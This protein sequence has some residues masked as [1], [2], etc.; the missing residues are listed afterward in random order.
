MSIKKN[1]Q[2]FVLLALLEHHTKFPSI[3]K[4]SFREA[5]FLNRENLFKF[6]LKNMATGNVE[7]G[8]SVFE[9]TWAWEQ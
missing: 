2:S 1:K 7:H 8:K 4:A 5:N 6:F 9:N 3:I